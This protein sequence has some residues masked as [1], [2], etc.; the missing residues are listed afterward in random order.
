MMIGHMIEYHIFA[1]R[2]HT[3]FASAFKYH[4]VVLYRWAFKKERD[5]GF[6]EF[7]LEVKFD[8]NFAL[9]ES[10]FIQISFRL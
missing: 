7:S 4:G 9:I 10:P 8:A 3:L 2:S 5:L 1:F 6:I